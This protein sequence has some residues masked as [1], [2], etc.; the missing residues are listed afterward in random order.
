MKTF[1]KKAT[2]HCVKAANECA[3][4]YMRFFIEIQHYLQ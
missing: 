2:Y 1:S 4:H 3:P